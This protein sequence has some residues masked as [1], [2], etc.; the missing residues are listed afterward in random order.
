MD[1]PAWEYMIVPLRRY[2]G[3]P[4]PNVLFQNGGAPFRL[5]N[6]L[7]NVI[8]A[9]RDAQIVHV[10]QGDFPYSL[11]V[12][13]IVKGDVPIVAGPNVIRVGTDPE[14]VIHTQGGFK[15]RRQ[16]LAIRFGFSIHFWNR[17]AFHHKSPF[18]R[19]E[20]IF[21]FR[22]YRSLG[23]RLGGM[24]EQR[25]EILPSGVRMDIF[26]P[27][28]ERISYP[29]D[30]AILYVGDARRMYLKGFDIF[31]ASL[32]GLKE[33]GIQFRGYVLGSTDARTEQMAREHGLDG[34]IELIGTVPRARLAPYYRGADVYVCPS[35]H[36]ADS[37][38]A[39][40]A[41]AC[42]TPVIGTDIPGINKTLSFQL[43]NGRD[44]TEKLIEV[45]ENKRSY[46]LQVQRQSSKWSI[47]NVIEKFK[48]IYYQ[49]TMRN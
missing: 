24:D 3:K 30:F 7:R 34:R 11:L 6:F 10:V 46:K 25:L 16:E 41:L 31:L 13:L 39:A 12:P 2:Y 40:E 42:G 36:E 17:L 23:I 5:T 29:T 44:L 14:W 47:E 35:R 20:R 43:G 37:T 27:I 33:R 21:V 32:K 19:F 26:Q 22:G 15:S 45:Y 28:G 4:S 49:L 1:D 38:T 18:C 9:S 8:K 48:E